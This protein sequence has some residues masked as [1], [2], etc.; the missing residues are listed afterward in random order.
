MTLV[1]HNPDL[2]GAK[3]PIYS[4]KGWIQRE[5]CLTFLITSGCVL[6]KIASELPTEEAE[7]DYDSPVFS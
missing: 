4:D 1:D 7:R 3:P 6:C 2:E 5:I